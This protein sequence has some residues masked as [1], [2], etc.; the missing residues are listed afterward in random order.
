MATLQQ[1]VYAVHVVSETIQPPM[2]E[3]RVIVI[4]DSAENAESKAQ[5]YCD[6]MNS[7]FCQNNLGALLEI[8]P[9]GWYN[10]IR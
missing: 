10:I 4:A 9:Y 2:S 6:N 5:D 7:C 1:F 8:R 3:E